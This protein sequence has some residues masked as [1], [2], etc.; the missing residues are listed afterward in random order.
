MQ[1]INQT[2]KI[3]NYKKQFKLLNCFFK[4]KINKYNNIKNEIV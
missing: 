3:S 1:S 4:I 2:Y